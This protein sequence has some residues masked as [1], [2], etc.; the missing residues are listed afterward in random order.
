MFAMAPVA[1]KIGWLGSIIL[2]DGETLWVET[3]KT[4]RGIYSKQTHAVM[5]VI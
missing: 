5:Y 2:F 3:G 4:K 1:A